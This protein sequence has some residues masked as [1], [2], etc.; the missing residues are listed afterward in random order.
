MSTPAGTV[1]S[2]QQHIYASDGAA[3]NTFGYSVALSDNGDTALVAAP[4]ATVGGNAYQGANYVFVRSGT[5]W[6]EQAKLTA[7]D[8]GANDFFGFNVEISGDGSTAIVGAY[9][10]D[11][12][13]NT[14]QGSAYVF[15]RS[16]TVWSQ[17]AKL[18]GS[19][20]G[21]GDRFGGSVSLSTS[22]DT[23]I[24]GA[25]LDDVGGTDQGSAYVFTR[26]G[27]V[28]AEQAKL[29]ASDGAA[30]DWFGFVSVASDGNT[31]CVGAMFDTVGGN[32]YQGSA[33]TYTRSGSIWTEQQHFSE[34]GGAAN[35]NFGYPTAMAG[36]G[37]TLVVGVT[38]DNSQQGSAYIYALG[39]GTPGG[40]I[41]SGTGVITVTAA[42]ADIQ[43]T[44]N[45]ST[46][47]TF[48]PS[49]TNR[50]I[51]LGTNVGGSLSLTDTEL[52]N[53]TAGIILNIG[54]AISGTITVS[55][56]ITHGNNVLLTTNA[57]L[58]AN[59]SFTMAANWNLTA[60]AISTISF[61]NTNADFTASGTGS[62][63]MTTPRNITMSSGSSI[64]TVDGDLTLKA[65]QQLTPTSGN[66]QGIDVNAASITV[67]GGGAMLL[68]GRGGDTVSGSQ[69]GIYIHQGA[70]VTGGKFLAPS[71]IE[72]TGGASSGGSNYGVLVSVASANVR[73]NGGDVQVTGKGGGTGGGNSNYGV[74]VTSTGYISAAITGATYVTGTGGNTSG[75]SDHGVYV[76]DS[77]SYISS[78]GGNVFVNGTGGGTGT[79]NIGVQV[80]S[81]STISAGGSGGVEVIGQGSTISTLASNYGVYVL[82][83][84]F[85]TS[86][87]GLT[88]VTGTGGGTGSANS[89]Y[90]VYANSTGNISSG[91]SDLTL[92]GKG[93]AGSGSNNYGA[94]L[95]NS[96]TWS[97]GKNVSVSGIEGSGTGT[98]GI[99]TIASSIYTGPT[100]NA[101]LIGNSQ[102][103][104]TSS[105]IN[106]TTNTVTFLTWN[107]GLA[108]DLG[109]TDVVGS[110]LGL[111]DQ[112]L[113]FVTA[114]KIQIGNSNAGS[115]TVSSPITRAVATELSFT[116]N[117]D[118][119]L[120][121]GLDSKGGNIGL[122][123]AFGSITQTAGTVNA[124][125][126]TLTLQAAG[127]Q[128][129]TFVIAGN[130]AGQVVVPMLVTAIINGS[131]DTTGFVQVDGT[132]G[133]T[134]GTVGTTTVS[135]TGKVAPGTSPG[136]LTTGN[137]AFNV[138]SEFTV[139][140]NGNSPGTSYDQ[141]A[142]NGTVNLGSAKL[143]GSVGYL[144]APGQV[145][146]IID[147]DGSDTIS[148]TFESQPEGSTVTFGAYKFII[149]YNGGDGNDVM[150]TEIPPP[151]ATVIFGDGTN[152]R[153][154][155]SQMVVNF[156]NGPV[157]FTGDVTAAITLSRN[158]AGSTQPGGNGPVALTA[159]PA[160]GSMSAVTITFSTGSLIDGFY[161]LK[162]D[163]SQV[164]G[165]GGKLDGGAGPGSDYV[166]TGT[167]TNKYFRLF[168]DSDGSGQ[169]D[170]LVDFIAFRNAFANGGP[171]P[172]FDYD[173][174]N[175]VDFLVDFIAFR[176]RFNA[177]P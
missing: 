104:A 48:V 136:K 17:Q 62:I 111:T 46:T 2:L 68:Q 105:S 113:D 135:N 9:I 66:F 107:M 38:V 103:Y 13:L 148:T 76:S 146:K 106:V 150:L 126:G 118:I 50:Q 45:N 63:G 91:G 78:G 132:L 167:T 14:D 1:W 164:S 130:K 52:D 140:L 19:D 67:S 70:V 116:T 33:Y 161:N 77:G 102:S 109:G 122:N 101:F 60:T 95:Q 34:A 133:G 22:G 28:W 56:P 47:V 115:I 160:N 110:K 87:G 117:F 72:G 131:F 93:G 145:F 166:V 97:A 12:G 144:P 147:N 143:F 159:I 32:S 73:T 120:N 4:G 127:G 114:S 37:K 57:A 170:F 134:N 96:S 123:C 15:T 86:N 10:D 121:Q 25:Y 74:A 58:T 173:T 155:V 169:V 7:S 89:A 128:T 139:E 39:P 65:N 119:Y 88:N 90:G 156:A 41:S 80:N 5:V 31:A 64:T 40:E 165:T 112:E 158:Q 53:I 84:S 142:V 172:V 36:D 61:A 30:N 163:A 177:T 162:I 82:V 152:Q 24:I 54:D 100:G 26:S 94:V 35:D 153:S 85:I 174:S 8:G 59:S 175:T 69:Y 23:A 3:Q 138:L 171:N 98:F 18:N 149:N 151:T 125:A 27:I 157:T 154:M 92:I 16:G 71:T 99:V 176:N 108:I 137:I 42:D 6:T 44:I 75:G 55:A 141:L 168:G 83:N 51:N 49:Q 124:G 43:G 20:S 29:T 79:Q 129:A 81:S 21:A 11:V